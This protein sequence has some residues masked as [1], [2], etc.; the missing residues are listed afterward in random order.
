MQPPRQLSG[1]TRLDD[2]RDFVDQ[3]MSE[4]WRRLLCWNNC[5]ER[6]CL[7]VA[8]PPATIKHIVLQSARQA[9]FRRC[10]KVAR[11]T[12]V[13]ELSR[14]MIRGVIRPSIAAGECSHARY[15]KA[16]GDTS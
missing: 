2:Q 12:F 10:E 13:G 6:A 1:P 15:R 16:R 3:E 4:A 5:R 11:M 7:R 8:T 14:A 9:R